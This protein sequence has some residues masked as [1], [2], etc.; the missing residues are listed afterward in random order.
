MQFVQVPKVLGVF[1]R[2]SNILAAMIVVRKK[3][4]YFYLIA[5]GSYYVVSAAVEALN[6]SEAVPAF[7]FALGLN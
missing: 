2:A 6:R 7:L 4:L 1:F 3:L 5:V